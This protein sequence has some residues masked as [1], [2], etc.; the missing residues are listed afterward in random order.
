MIMASASQD[1]QI[2]LWNLTSG[3]PI[4]YLNNHTAEIGYGL[5]VYIGSMPILV[6]GAR[7]QWIDLWNISTAQLIRRFNTGKDVYALGLMVEN[8]V[9]RLR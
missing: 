2:I 3:L 1:G 8:D 5:D 9:A 7:D 4:A 6:S